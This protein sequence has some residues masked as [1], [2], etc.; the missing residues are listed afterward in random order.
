M[1]TSTKKTSSKKSTNKKTT[2]KK[3][4]KE[5]FKPFSLA[6]YTATSFVAF[7]IAL[8]GVVYYL[9]NN[10]NNYVRPDYQAVATIYHSE[11][12][13]NDA[14]DEY[15]YSIFENKNKSNTYFYIK[16]KSSI[17]MV[18]SGESKDIKSGSIK[19]KSDLN[20]IVKDIEKDTKSD[21]TKFVSYRYLVNDDY[22]KLDTLEELENKLFAK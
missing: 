6:T 9:Y 14:G 8:V 21:S 3:V 13:G 11:M 10:S 22:V 2:N 20:K 4:I 5:G 18:G 19:T 16:S 15:I 7:V 1:S 17:T 12:I